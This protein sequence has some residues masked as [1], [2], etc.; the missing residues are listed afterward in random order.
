MVLNSRNSTWEKNIVGARSSI[1][2]NSFKQPR[3][4]PRTF[5]CV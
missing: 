3:G 5:H 4:D 1:K 2:E